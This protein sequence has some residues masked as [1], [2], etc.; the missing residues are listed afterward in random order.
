MK[1]QRFDSIRKISNSISDN[2]KRIKAITDDISTDIGCR[3]RE[4]RNEAQETQNQLSRVFGV[5]RAQIA[6]IES[7]NSP[8]TLHQIII[9]CTHYNVSADWLLFGE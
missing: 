1:D 5:S 7:G 2:S 4:C 6:N 8:L 3:V 9:M